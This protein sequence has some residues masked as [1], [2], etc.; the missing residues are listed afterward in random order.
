MVHGSVSGAKPVGCPSQP[1]S[2][3]LMAADLG[4]QSP[5][6]KVI[7]VGPPGENSLPREFAQ[8]TSVLVMVSYHQPPASVSTN[9]AHHARCTRGLH[10]N[11][12]AHGECTQDMV[13]VP[14]TRAPKHRSHSGHLLFV[15]HQ[16]FIWRKE[17]LARK[18]SN[19]EAPAGQGGPR[20]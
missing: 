2:W 13:V 11:F 12:T 15:D 8:L 16:L 5:V 19:Q 1:E 3:G 10:M 6:S 7:G 17:S 20:E 14:C 9:R 18:C 4:G